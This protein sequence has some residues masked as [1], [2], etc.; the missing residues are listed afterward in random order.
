[1]VGIASNHDVG[2]WVTFMGD[3]DDKISNRDAGSCVIDSPDAGQSLWLSVLT[4]PAERLKTNG[5]P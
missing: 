1:M 2:S 3:D 4:S 5:Q